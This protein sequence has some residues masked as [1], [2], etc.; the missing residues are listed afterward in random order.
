MLLSV[1]E[2]QALQ[3]AGGYILVDCRFDLADLEAGYENYLD[4]HIPGAVYAH[5]DDDL[6]GPVTGASGRHPLPD[7]AKFASFLARAGWQPGMLLVAY[8]DAGGAIAARLWWLMRY[9]G[10]DCA[11]LLDGGIPAWWAARGDVESGQSQ[12][13]PVEITELHSREGL[14]ISTAEVIAGI[15][16]KEI[17][18][19]D[20]RAN[21][22]FIGRVEPI[23]NV[24][25]HIPGSK[26][27]PYNRNLNANGTFRFLDEIRHGLQ[28]LCGHQGPDQLV[29]MCGSGVTACQN[30]FSWG[31]HG[32]FQPRN[33]W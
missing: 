30:L 10:Q 3:N 25:G 31:D 15:E 20:A 14:E 7:A 23:D 19:V 5:L 2:L 11:A 6:S 1:S 29:H 16:R 26:N 33:A 4:S 18:L 12:V 13:K 28:D 27:Y 9:F 8:D 22:R 24:A 21:E 32:P 17:V